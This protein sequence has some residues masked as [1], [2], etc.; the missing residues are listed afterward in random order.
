MKQILAFLILGFIQQ[1]ASA[2]VECTGVTRDRAYVTVRV[3]TTD[4]T[5]APAA[6]EVIME[7]GGNKYGYRFA[8]A[9]VAQFF[10]DDA[11][12]RAIVGVVAYVEKEFPVSV[13]YVGTNHVDMDL[14]QILADESVPKSAT[15]LLRI[16]RGP[17]YA[18]TEQIVADKIVCSVWK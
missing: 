13:K 10:E 3:G 8:G 7:K 1:A 12:N 6:G 17:G 15:N 14:K 4:A 16:W 5:G 2:N 9:E 18:S 11:D